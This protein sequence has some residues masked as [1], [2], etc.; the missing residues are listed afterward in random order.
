MRIE[1]ETSQQT[2]LEYFLWI[3]LLGGYCKIRATFINR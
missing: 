3:Q 1:T 2:I